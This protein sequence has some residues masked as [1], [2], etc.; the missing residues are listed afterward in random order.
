MPIVAK[1]AG[2]RSAQPDGVQRGVDGQGDANRDGAD[3]DS[4][5]HRPLVHEYERGALGLENE[6]QHIKVT[7]RA[8][9]GGVTRRALD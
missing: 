8:I 1:C 9:R 4:V 6:R 2:F 3:V 7:G 5:V